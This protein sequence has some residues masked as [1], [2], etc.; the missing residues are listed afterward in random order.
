MTQP[1]THPGMHQLR[2]AVPDLD[3]EPAQAVL[4]TTLPGSPTGT[5]AT[6]RPLTRTT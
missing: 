2:P 5:L 6:A 4:L 3:E 1:T